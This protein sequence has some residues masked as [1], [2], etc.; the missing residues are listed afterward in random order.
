VAYLEEGG[1]S[2]RNGLSGG[3]A[4]QQVMHDLACQ[5]G[6]HGIHTRE[7]SFPFQHTCPLTSKTIFAG[8]AGSAVSPES[9]LPN[10]LRI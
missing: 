8:M 7:R 9:T 1:G 6:G 3:Q 4:L 2:Q 10:R 5:E